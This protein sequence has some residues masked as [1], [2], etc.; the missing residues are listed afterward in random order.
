MPKPVAGPRFRPASDA[1]HRLAAAALLIALAG[2]GGGSGDSGGM[3][4]IV[5]Q[6]NAGQIRKE[7]TEAVGRVQVTANSDGS[8][9]ATTGSTST[10]EST[11][12]SASPTVAEVTTSSELTASDALS[13]TSTESVGQTTADATTAVLTATTAPS[14]DDPVAIAF[15]EAALAAVNQAR[16]QPR[17]CGDRAMPA[18]APL[19]WHARVAYAALLESEWM[20]Q[21]NTFGH[22]WENGELVWDRLVMAGY[23]WQAADEN[24]AAGFDTLAEAMQAWID[25]PPHCVALMRADIEDVGISVLPGLGGSRYTSYWT[26]ALGTAKKIL[27]QASP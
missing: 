6:G 14:T 18:V 24:I 26:M 2:C 8:T 11:A 23:L 21:R 1:R 13:P 16:A 22:A 3:E 27:T 9:V 4:P 7:F 17:T 10:T 19:R 5:A 15:R 12:V 20:Q 25:S